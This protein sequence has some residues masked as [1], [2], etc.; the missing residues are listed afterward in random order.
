M[1]EKV[2]GDEQESERWGRWCDEGGGDN[3][4]PKALVAASNHCHGPR[5]H[6]GRDVADAVPHGNQNASRQP[7]IFAVSPKW[8]ASVALMSS[9]A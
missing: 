3:V 5:E 8:R 6:Q 4:L 2:P 1:R 7:F 9:I